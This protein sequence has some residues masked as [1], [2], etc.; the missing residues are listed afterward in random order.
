MGTKGVTP[1]PYANPIPTIYSCSHI[2]LLRRSSSVTYT[3]SL[4]CLSRAVLERH[5]VS[6]KVATVRNSL[7]AFLVPSLTGG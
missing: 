7:V 3:S 4:R 6:A 2:T 5:A 1:I